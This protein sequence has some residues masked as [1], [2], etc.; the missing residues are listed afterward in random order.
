MAQALINRLPILLMD[1]VLSRLDAQTRALMENKPELEIGRRFVRH[2]R[3]EEAIAM[4][5]QNSPSL[6]PGR[7]AMTILFLAASAERRRSAVYSRRNL[8]NCLGNLKRRSWQRML[9]TNAPSLLQV[10]LLSPVGAWNCVKPSLDRSILLL[11]A[12]IGARAFRWLSE[13]GFCWWPQ[14]HHHPFVTMEEMIAD[15]RWALSPSRGRIPPR[16]SPVRS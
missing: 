8:P 11:P 7:P 3:S 13:P 10:V 14:H 9:R 6:L 1:C 12:S 15:S 2:P 4:A 16:S 5:D